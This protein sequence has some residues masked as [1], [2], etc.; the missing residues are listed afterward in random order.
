MNKEATRSINKLSK[1][2]NKMFGVGKNC[3]MVIAKTFYKKGSIATWEWFKS[4][5]AE[6]IPDKDYKYNDDDNYCETCHHFWGPDYTMI[7]KK[8]K[9]IWKDSCYGDEPNWDSVS[10]KE[11]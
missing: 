11:K 10:E 2:I 6:F 4:H 5:G 9:M 1:K 8:R 3:S 7:W